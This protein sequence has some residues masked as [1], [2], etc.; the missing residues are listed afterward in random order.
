MGI[1]AGR[2]KSMLAEA[3]RNGHAP[4]LRNAAHGVE[5]PEPDEAGKDAMAWEPA[6]DR[7]LLACELVSGV[8][9]RQLKSASAENMIWAGRTQSFW[10]AYSDALLMGRPAAE[11]REVL[12]QDP[13]EILARFASDGR[14]AARERQ[15]AWS[16]LESLPGLG[17]LKAALPMG[18]GFAEVGEGKGWMAARENLYYC[19]MHA[20]SI[21]KVALPILEN[22]AG[23]PK[24]ADLNGELGE[25]MRSLVSTEEEYRDLFGAAGRACVEKAQLGACLSV[26]N[27]SCGQE[28]S[29]WARRRGGL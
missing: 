9:E 25:F 17:K 13:A 20:F 24:L 2:V 21:V 5:L 29:G 1:W 12:A 15:R 19:S 8:L 26:G 11:A 14:F 23:F 3:I 16:F 28:K 18:H 22:P 10:E 6:S 27:E 7:V 4:S